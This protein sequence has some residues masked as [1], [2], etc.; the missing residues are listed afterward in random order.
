MDTGGGGAGECGCG[1]GDK[2]EGR[3]IRLKG[4]LGDLS[5]EC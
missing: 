1:V 5:C 3:S 2:R 4:R